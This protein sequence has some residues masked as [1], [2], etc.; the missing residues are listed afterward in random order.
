LDEADPKPAPKT[1]EANGFTVLGK[2]RRKPK[3]F[4][5]LGRDSAGD[6]AE[7]H[8]ELDASAQNPAGAR[9][10]FGRLTPVKDPR[11]APPVAASAR[12]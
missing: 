4:E 6:M 7:L 10:R 2:P 3:H 5:V 12:L 9:R 11:A 8:I 1:A